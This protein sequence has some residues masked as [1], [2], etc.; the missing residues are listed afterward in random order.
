MTCATV[1]VLTVSAAEAESVASHR[2]AHEHNIG[3]YFYTSTV[4]RY[5]KAVNIYGGWCDEVRH[6]EVEQLFPFK[7]VVNRVAWC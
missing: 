6:A 5:A 2:S 4:V 1:L 3:K 7:H